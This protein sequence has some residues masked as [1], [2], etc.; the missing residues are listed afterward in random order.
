[1]KPARL[2][3][4]QVLCTV[5]D[6]ASLARALPPRLADSDQPALTQELVYGALRWH[7]RIEGLLR[8]LLQ[9]P[10]RNK[11]RIL[12]CLLHIGLYQLM[13][14]DLPAHA[15]VNETVAL[16]GRLNR[17]WAR[18]LV[19]AVLRRYQRE[20][21]ALEAALDEAERL[22]H[23]RWLLDRLQRAWP[24]DWA[25]ICAENNRRPPMVLRVNRLRQNRETCLQRLAEA[26]IAAHAHPC[27]PVAVELEQPQPVDTLPGFA[28]GALSV[29]DAA[30]QLAAL[31]LDPQPGERI[32][33]ACAAPGGKTA[34]LLE[35]AGGRLD[36]LALELDPDRL[37][38]LRDTLARLGL[39]AEIRQGDAARP[40]DW[41]DGRPFDRILL[42]APCSATGVLRRNPDIRVHR[43]P[44][45]IARL[46]ATQQTLLNAL[47]PL[48]RP[49]GRLLYATCSVLPEEN[50]EQ[51]AAFLAGQPDAR[52]CALTVDCG[53]D[54]QAGLQILPGDEGMDG[55][56]HALIE[57]H[58]GP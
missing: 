38:A 46:Q 33:D 50:R 56:F 32:L 31:L 53:R 43:R 36:L 42:D 4:S 24:Q 40:D 20:R 49:G 45:D 57:K 1:M 29:Q 55:F 51:I 5:L 35:H 27:S 16:T 41:W 23:P 34:H 47:W 28:E 10:I 7:F 39:A 8:Q 19:N 25:R 12:R 58:R 11:D 2:V 48:L 15:A 6:G 37:P 26:G 14:M 3:A 52:L 30:A 44:Q 54:T 17:P 13:E 18:G 9:K 22:S 21:E